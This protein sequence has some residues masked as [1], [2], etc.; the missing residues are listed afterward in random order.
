M[1]QVY[2]T[3]APDLEAVQVGNVRDRIVQKAWVVKTCLREVSS[4][5]VVLRTPRI[6]G[7]NFSQ[8]T[9][10]NNQHI[11]SYLFYPYMNFGWVLRSGDAEY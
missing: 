1:T 2:S 8:I 9:P 6:S 4:T 3:V 11:N 10:E 7:L 5:V